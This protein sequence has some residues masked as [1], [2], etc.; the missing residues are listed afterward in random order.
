MPDVAACT[1]ATRGQLPAARVLAASYVRHHPGHTFTTVV[2]DGDDDLGIE[3]FRHLAL[4]LTPGELADAVAPHVIRRLLDEHEVVI[5]LA[6]ESLVLAPFPS[7]GTGLTRV[8]KVLTPRPGDT[9][10]V[11]DVV[12]AVGRDAKACLDFWPQKAAFEHTVLRDPGFALAHWNLHER[13]LANASLIQFPGYDP[14]TPWML[15]AGHAEVLLSERPELREI[16]DEYRELLL[17]NGYEEVPYGFASLVDGTPITEPMRTLF[18]AEKSLPQ[19][20]VAWLSE[21]STPTERNAGLNRLLMAVWDAR[22][23][24]RRAFPRPLHEPGFGDWCREWGVREGVPTWAL[25]TEP[26]A[27]QPPTNEF[28]VNVAGFHTAELGIGEMGR[29]ALRAIKAAGIP[30][31]SVV[32]EHSITNT[33]RTALD[34]PDS[35]GAPRFPISLITV[36][37]DSTRA[38]LEAH[39]EVGHER[40]RI[41]LWAWELEDFPASMHSGFGLVDEVWAVSDFTRD[42]IAKHSP[43]PVKTFPVPVPDPGEPERGIGRTRF[44]FAFDH[45]STAGRKNPYGLVEA[46]HR[47]F[48]DRDDVE[49]VIKSTNSHLHAPAA[50]RLRLQAADDKR[51]TLIERYLKVD[52]LHDLYATSTAYVSLHRSEGFGLTVAEAMIRGMAVIST[53]YS[54]TPEFVDDKTG[55]PIP[56]TMVEVGEGWPPYQP[57]ARW[58]DPDLDAAAQAMREIAE[59][60]DEAR[61]RGRAA[62]EHLLKIRSVDAAGQWI[63]EQL[64]QAHEVWRTRQPVPA[65]I[66]RRAARL[67]RRVVRGDR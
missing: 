5:R 38:L 19:D 51:I 55:W 27:V 66:A 64:R 40:Y 46:F 39:P 62:R 26:A 21:P 48:P 3:N 60:P 43:I 63:T 61:K 24:L 22:P 35:V 36:N 12:V 53:D 28:G 16:T 15:S 1:V 50:E 49:L 7:F 30:H 11:D 42:A 20:L 29:V 41:G 25:P 65:S 4:S 2:L 58:A 59:D 32:E 54:S 56:F 8:A 34:K 57:E 52:E 9:E 45:N 10:F 14:N 37:G 31:V 6:P 13:D 23:D 67:V 44:L 18:K 33:V 47:A 17:A